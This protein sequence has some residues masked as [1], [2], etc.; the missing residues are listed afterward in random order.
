MASGLDL[1]TLTFSTE[2]VRDINVLVFDEVMK[3]PDMQL[4]HTIF[5]D[6]VFNKE[7]GFLGEGGMIGKATS[8]CSITATEWKVGSRKITWVPK[9]WGFLIELC[10]ADLET[11]A[12]VYALN[13]GVE[14]SDLTQTEYAAIM[15][16]FLA[17]AI[18]KFIYRVVWFG[19]TAADNIANGGDITDGVDATFFTLLDGLFK[20]M[21]TQVT[22]NPAQG[23]SIAENAG[24]TYA[25]QVMVDAN[26]QGYLS[27]IYYQADIRLR[28]MPDNFILCTQSVYDS[29]QRSLMADKIESTYKNLTEGI[30]VLTY[31]GIPLIPMQIWDELIQ[32]NNDTTAKWV[33]PNRA[34]FTNKKVLGIAVDSTTSFEN[35]KIWLDDETDKTKMKARGKIDAKLQNPLFF[36]YA[37]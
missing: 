30:S 17:V 6:I 29:Y 35:L 25:T 36:T 15:V 26:V 24:L 19:D 14:I 22:A 34:V 31:N 2:E 23:V 20:Q 4:I 3:A 13:K 28:S 32:A 10:F 16:E 1:S 33:S 9:D 5:P 11:T 8:G 18:R 12:A 7:V 27:K 21:D 37:V